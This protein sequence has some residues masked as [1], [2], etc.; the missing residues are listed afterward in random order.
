MTKNDEESNL[1]QR[2]IITRFVVTQ[3]S[4]IV[5]MNLV[6]KKTQNINVPE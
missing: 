2:L 4:I 5:L 1:S 6:R 3:D